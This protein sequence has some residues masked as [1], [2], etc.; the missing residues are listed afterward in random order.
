MSS[1]KKITPDF[2]FIEAFADFH[3]EMTDLETSYQALSNEIQ[4]LNKSLS[5]KTGEL[6]TRLEKAHRLQQ[7]LDS[8]LNSITEGVIV[9]D[10]RERIVLFNRGAEIL[11]EYSRDSVI[12][13]KY[14]DMIGSRYTQRFSPGY[15]LKYGEALLHQEKEIITRSGQKVPVRFSTTPVYDQQGRL[16]G[17]VEVMTDLKRLKQLEAVMQRLKTQASLAHMAGLVAHEIR[18]PLGGLLGHV[19]LLMQSQN[20]GE[21]Q[22]TLDAIKTSINQINHIVNRF[23]LF[24]KPVQPHFQSVDLNK[25]ILDVIQI[26]KKNNQPD[27]DRILIEFRPV[28]SKPVPLWNID[29]LLME[30]VLLDIMDNAEKAI[31]DRGKIV[32]RLR[33]KSKP[34]RDRAMIISISDSGIGMDDAVLNQL[35]VPFFTTRAR[36]MGLSLAVARNFVHFH[37]GEIDIKSEVGRGSTFSIK[38]PK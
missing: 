17:V 11:T 19:D 34:A 27:P 26:F 20:P 30:Q 2:H 28:T 8:I 33:K 32:I 36:G 12:G 35:F 25:F 38:L 3:S 9:I 14:M 22:A 6:E 18:N 29:P 15:T 1:K 16:S 24:S 23:Q 31:Q 5:I 4:T 7:F 37:R 13:K 10:S 21:Q